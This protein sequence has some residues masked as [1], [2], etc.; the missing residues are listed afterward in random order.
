VVAATVLGCMLAGLAVGAYLPGVVTRVPAGRPV[1]AG[2][3]GPRERRSAR[4]GVTL[5]LVTAVV[6]GLLAAR[7]GLS[8]ELPAYLYLGAAGVALAV[9]DLDCRRLPDSLTL[10]SYA[11]GIALLGLA[12][13]SRRD[14]GALLRAIAAMAVLFAV[15][16]LLAL[17]HPKGMG[18][19]DVK[20]A[21]VLGLY[22]GWLGW[23]HVLLGPFVAFL[24]SAVGGLGLIATGR[25]TLK[26]ALPFGPFLLAGALVAVLW[27]HPLAHWYAGG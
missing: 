14:G 9:I 23:A 11:V 25:A 22:L 13:L 18:F 17:I 27:G 20:L 2:G 15:F 24:L 12:A 16:Y 8:A 1:L 6:F 3:L 26:S 10:P 5:V 7:F 4:R 19:G 21:G